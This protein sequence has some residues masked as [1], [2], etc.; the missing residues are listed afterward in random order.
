MWHVYVNFRY[1]HVLATLLIP[2]IDNLN[3]LSGRCTKVQVLMWIDVV[4][5]L[6]EQLLGT[7]GSLT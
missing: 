5:L 1:H 4:L 6:C 2:A 7:N 3:R